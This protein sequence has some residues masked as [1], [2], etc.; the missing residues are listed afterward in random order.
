MAA[1][2]KNASAPLDVKVALVGGADTGKSSLV[3]FLKGCNFE[4]ESEYAMAEHTC[5]DSW[6]ITVN[7]IEWDYEDSKSKTK[8][9]I[10]FSLWESGGSFLKKFPFYNDYLLKNSHLIVYMISLLSDDNPIER[11]T[12]LVQST[13]QTWKKTTTQKIT[14]LNEIVLLTKADLG[15]I[16]SEHVIDGVKDYCK[17]EGISKMRIIGIPFNDK[18][19]DV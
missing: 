11:L 15:L 13:R 3:R 8:Q 7:I 17:T 9:K 1:A 4:K 16:M 19:V 10:R 6:G 5:H 18:P 14:K 2:P 12:T